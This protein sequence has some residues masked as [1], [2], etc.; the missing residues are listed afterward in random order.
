MMARN[1]M[2]MPIAGVAEEMPG[3]TNLVFDC[4]GFSPDITSGKD[5][6]YANQIYQT[7]LLVKPNTDIK[8]LTAKIDRLYKKAALTDTSRVAR[9]AI[10]KPG[11]T[12]IYLDPLKNLHLKPHYGSN[13]SYH[14][15]N[16]LMI[17]AIVV[18][19]VTGINFTNFYLAKADQ[20]AKEVGIKKMNGMVKRQIAFQFML[21]ILLQ[22]LVAMLMALIVVALGLPYFNR[23]LQV[24]LFF[25][26]INYTIILQVCAT[27]G[28]LTLIAGIYPALIMAGFNPAEVLQRNQLQ[29]SGK[30]SWVQSA[31]TVLQFACAIIF[32]ITLSVVNRQVNY[33]KTQDVG[34]SAKQ[35]LYI[36]NL[37]LFNTPIKFKRI[38]EQIQA[39][40]GVQHVTVASN[41]PGGF[42]PATYQFSTRQSSA[43]LNAISVDYDYFETLN[44]KTLK[45]RV[46]SETFKA[47]SSGVV[48]NE[49][50]AKAMN[51]K[52]PLGQSIESCGGRYQIIGVINNV[53]A[54]GFEQNVQPTAYLL[55]DHCGLS[56][57]Q[58][59]ISANARAISQLLNTLNGKWSS[60]N[61]VDGD[62]FNYHFLDELYGQLFIKQEQLQTVL[63]WFSA[64]AVG[65]ASLGFFASAA[66]ALRLRLKET[67]IRKVFGAGQHQ[68]LLTLSKPFFYVMALANLI[69]WPVAL[70]LTYYWLSTFAYRVNLSWVPFA[71]AMALSILIVFICVCLQTLRF[72]NFNPA[73]KLKE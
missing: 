67:A 27:L 32:V 62:N 11:E 59:M 44:I 55:N 16:G 25:S 20:R 33:M 52:Q 9:A 47:D 60:I 37:A 12:A 58:I 31:I 45:G 49:A 51:L 48:I 19:I 18:L 8:Q 40:P 64:L 34:F 38:R 70:L 35:V 22:C 30:L 54:Y 56:K 2:P 6:S 63:F 46:F 14:L 13:N 15:V 21:E 17:L 28:L 42:L 66:Y 68:L 3:N 29:K 53:K 36:D 41:V 24:N 43:A 73:I 26:G 65:I 50:A 71:G 69:A 23:I 72:I 1:G 10:N 7:Y 61:K 57:T 39:L 4:I 5:Q